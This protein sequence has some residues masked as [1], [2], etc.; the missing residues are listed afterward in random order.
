[1]KKILLIITVILAGCAAPVKSADKSAIIKSFPNDAAIKQP[2]I[3]SKPQIKRVI[4][5]P[6]IVQ[7]VPKEEIQSEDNPVSDLE[8]DYILKRKILFATVCEQHNV[9]KGLAKKYIRSIS[10]FFDGKIETQ[11]HI[12]NGFSTVIMQYHLKNDER[13]VAEVTC[14]LNETVLANKPRFNLVGLKVN[15]IN[16]K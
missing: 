7:E 5:T 11:T 15:G 1:M 2:Q 10:G 6:A 16:I 8:D 9:I 12:S 13:P 3:K 14:V 4:K